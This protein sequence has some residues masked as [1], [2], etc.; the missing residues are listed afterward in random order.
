MSE[1]SGAIYGDLFGRSTHRRA[2]RSPVLTAGLTFEGPDD[3]RGDPAAIEGARLGNYLL[4]IYGAPF[5][6]GRVHRHVAE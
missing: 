5:H 6:A 2:A 3:G 1:I 4:T